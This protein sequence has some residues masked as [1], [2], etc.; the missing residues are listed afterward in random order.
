MCEFSSVPWL[1]LSPERLGSVFLVP[2]S[3]WKIPRFSG[4]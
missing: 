4:E 3:A 1:C 2:G